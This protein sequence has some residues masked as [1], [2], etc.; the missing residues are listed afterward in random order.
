MR[1]KTTSRGEKIPTKPNIVSWGT[2]FLEKGVLSSSITLW[3]HYMKASGKE[4]EGANEIN[5]R[6]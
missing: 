4:G 5:R 1:G 2:S 3:V 6:D